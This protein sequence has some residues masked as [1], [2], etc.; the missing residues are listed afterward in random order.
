MVAQKY[1]WKCIVK[2]AKSS[3]KRMHTKMLQLKA[4]DG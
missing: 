2:L 3:P 4:E 1:S